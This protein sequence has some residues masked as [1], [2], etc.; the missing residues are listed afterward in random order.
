MYAEKGVVWTGSC[1]ESLS[2]WDALDRMHALETKNGR[3]LH[4][5][6]HGGSDGC[7]VAARVV[8]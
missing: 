7:F 3:A 5:N 8:P 1:R 2:Y 6:L 4:G